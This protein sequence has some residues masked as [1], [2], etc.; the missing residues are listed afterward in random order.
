MD[1]EVIRVDGTDRLVGECYRTVLRP[2]FPDDE[3]LTPA[4]FAHG[5]ATGAI[6]LHTILVDG[7][8]AAVATGD[9]HDDVML[10]GYL[11][12]G[13]AGRGRGLGGRLLDTVV[14]AW[15]ADPAPA[16]ILA[17]VERPDRHPGS[18]EHGDP[19][20]RLRF[21]ARHGAR[22]LDL[23]YFQPPL[24]PGGA[25]VDGMLLLALGGANATLAPA[26]PLLSFFDAYLDDSPAAARLRAAVGPDGVRLLDCADYR[27]IPASG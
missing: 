15:R 11:A 19:T 1:G 20:A 27:D 5:V 3:L 7:V 16:L 26:G 12:V 17:E 8:P 2:S 23:P 13:A 4:D 9:G 21:Y 14:A 22:V 10:L 6:R 24:R 18:P 25:A